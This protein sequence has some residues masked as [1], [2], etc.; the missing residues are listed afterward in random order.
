VLCRPAN[1]STGEK[2]KIK[3]NS[4]RM[5]PLVPLDNSALLPLKTKNKEHSTIKVLLFKRKSIDLFFE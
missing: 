1:A 4:K 5:D 2:I 3:I